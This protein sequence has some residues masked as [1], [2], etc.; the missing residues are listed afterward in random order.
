MKSDKRIPY[1]IVKGKYSVIL[2]LPLDI[3]INEIDE[4]IVIRHK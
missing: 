1:Q 3:T 2:I 4:S